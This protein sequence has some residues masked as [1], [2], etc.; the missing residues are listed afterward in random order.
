VREGRVYRTFK[1]T[2]LTVRASYTHR[3]QMRPW[4]KETEHCKSLPSV[5]NTTVRKSGKRPSRRRTKP[6]SRS[7]KIDSARGHSR[8]GRQVPPCESRVYQYYRVHLQ[9]IPS[10]REWFRKAFPDPAYGNG[11]DSGRRTGSR[12]QAKRG[13]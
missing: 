8:T 7:S 1:S 4:R 10:G 5:V 2:T 6:F 12:K 3:D 13:S 11:A 9:N